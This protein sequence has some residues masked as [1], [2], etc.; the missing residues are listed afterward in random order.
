MLARG[1][2]KFW[3]DECSLNCAGDSMAPYMPKQTACKTAETLS[4]VNYTL[5]EDSQEKTH[6]K[7]TG[8]RPN[9]PPRRSKDTVCT[10]KH[11]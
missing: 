7:V 2:R 4:V 3:G 8:N 1:S 10:Q 5:V 9:Q 11:V 6:W